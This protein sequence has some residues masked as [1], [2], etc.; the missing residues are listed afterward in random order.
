MSYKFSYKSSIKGLLTYTNN[1][2]MWYGTKIE[3]ILRC[4]AKA[5]NKTGQRLSRSSGKPG[6]VLTNEKNNLYVHFGYFPSLKK[7]FSW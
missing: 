6:N 3:N 2:C 5:V 7:Y 4:M 1:L